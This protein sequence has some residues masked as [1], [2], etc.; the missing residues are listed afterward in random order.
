MLKVDYRV[1]ILVTMGLA[2]L[3]GQKFEKPDVAQLVAESDKHFEAAGKSVL[4]DAKAW[5]AERQRLDTVAGAIEKA[6]VSLLHVK[7]YRRL[8][9]S[10]FMLCKGKGSEA[11]DSWYKRAEE[12][13][14]ALKEAGPVEQYEEKEA[15]IWKERADNLVLLGK[16][17]RARYYLEKALRAARASSYK[18]KLGEATIRDRL[19]GISFRKEQWKETLEIVGPA[20]AIIMP[21]KDQPGFNKEALRMPLWYQA[22]ST[23]RLKNDAEPLFDRYLKEFEKDISIHDHADVYREAAV[24][25]GERS[26]KEA[27]PERT[28]ALRKA[29]GLILKAKQII[30]K[31]KEDRD[32]PEK[33]AILTDLA[34]SYARGGMGEEAVGEFKDALDVARKSPT[35]GKDWSGQIPILNRYAA[36]LKGLGRTAEAEAQLKEV[37]R[38]EKLHQ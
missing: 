7:V 3:L 38:I 8:G 33:I 22:I 1:T 31:S 13:L 37:K 28:A 30:E 2:A 15:T 36:V 35:L 26:P 25:V 32:A 14:D 29:H 21:L 19:A 34:M 24:N 6:P 23:A 11:A 12:V 17:D 18:D 5:E 10:N 16:E 20:V 9:A 4:L 27:G